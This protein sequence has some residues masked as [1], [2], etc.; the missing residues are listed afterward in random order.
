MTP[1]ASFTVTLVVC[2]SSRLGATMG[3]AVT[4]DSTTG[5]CLREG[6]SE[7]RLEPKTRRM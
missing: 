2:A 7:S 4:L 5:I 1:G 3:A 6:C